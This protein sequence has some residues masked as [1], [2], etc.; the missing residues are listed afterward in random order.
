YSAPISLPQGGDQQVQ[1]RTQTLDDNVDEPNETYQ[2]TAELSD[3]TSTVSDTGTAT[4]VDN[5][6]DAPTASQGS[7]A[8][9]DEGL[10]SGI[11]GGT[12]DDPTTASATFSDLLPITTGGDVPVMVD[13]AVMDG[14]A[15]TIGQEDVLYG[16]AS[17]VLTATITDSPDTGRVGETLF[18]VTVDNATTGAYTVALAR[19]VLH[20]EGP[21]N[22]NE[23]DPNAVLTYTVTDSDNSTASNSL[24]VSFDDDEPSMSTFAGLVVLN[25]DDA[26]DSYQNTGFLPGA[27]GWGGITLTGPVLTGITYTSTTLADGTVVLT[28]NDGV[29]DIFT[30]SLSEDGQYKFVLLDAEAGTVETDVAFDRVVAGSPGSGY[31]FGDVV[32]TP[33][34][35]NADINPSTTGLAGDSNSLTVN[36]AITFTFDNAQDVDQLVFGLKAP[37]GAT[38]DYQF[39][40]GTT[41][42]ESD[43]VSSNAAPELVIS[44]TAPF[45][46][47]ELTV[48]SS[49]ASLKITS[50]QTIDLVAAPGQELPFSVNAVDGDGDAISGTIHVQVSPEAP[51]EL[52]APSDQQSF[53]QTEPDVQATEESDGETPLLSTEGDDVF[54]F[55]LAD[56]GVSELTTIIGFG[57]N[58][59]DFLDLRELLQGEESEDVDLTSYLKVSLD[60]DNTVIEVSSSGDFKGTPSDGNEV[61]QTIVLQDV[62]LVT[63]FDDPAAIIQNMIEN[64]QLD[65]D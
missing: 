11:V 42:L 45:T 41:L 6:D 19:N 18:T 64:G 23:T 30:L 61:D 46:A 39:Y 14:E 29:N 20:A 55:T 2:L 33:T 32:A 50:L 7:A 17:G 4:I 38:F 27:D 22:E 65:I 57:D 60:G 47:I 54:A 25:V 48:V 1:V 36:E 59:S 34:G 3:G 62:D 24:I 15:G 12:F 63:G 53:Q 52:N 10:D 5:D 16:W 26:T 43:T 13:F 58:G 21:N 37:Q 40:N 8:L 31:D 51:Q 49:P 44:P 9:D 35:T 28:A 56:A